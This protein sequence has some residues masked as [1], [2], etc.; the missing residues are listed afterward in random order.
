MEYQDAE[1]I[2]SKLKCHYPEMVVHIKDDG[3]EKSVV[4]TIR[5]L[6]IESGQLPQLARITQ[7]RKLNFGRSGPNFRVTIG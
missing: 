4:G 2:A 1:A 5:S 7:N 6:T 3:Q